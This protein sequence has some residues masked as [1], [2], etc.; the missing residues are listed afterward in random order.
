MNDDRTRAAVEAAAKA[1]YEQTRKKRQSNPARNGAATCE[2][3]VRPIVEAAL[4]ASD[5][6]VAA[7]CLN[8]RSDRADWRVRDLTSAN[9]GA[10][11]KQHA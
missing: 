2:L 10:V 9:E 5:A 6:Y 8:R 7:A 11:A 4:V 1:F 3:F